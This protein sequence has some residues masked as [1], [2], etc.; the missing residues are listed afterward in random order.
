MQYCH[1]NGLLMPQNG[2]IL[3]FS[4]DPNARHTSN[5]N[6][7]KRTKTI[8]ITNRFYVRRPVTVSPSAITRTGRVSRL[9][10]TPTSGA[11]FAR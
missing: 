2:H 5:P 8:S 7:R 6:C 11:D 1:K 9:R 3:R 4:K 10:Y